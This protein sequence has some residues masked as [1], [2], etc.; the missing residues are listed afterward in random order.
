VSEVIALGSD[1]GGVGLKDIIKEHLEQKGLTVLDCGTQGDESVDY[2]DFAEAV[3]FVGL[4]S[5]LVLKRTV[6]KGFVLRLCI[7]RLPQ[8][9][10]RP[11]IMRTSCV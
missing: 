2:P 4:G 6:T 8:K 5:A 1:H 11:I 10:Q 7:A 3:G 9:W